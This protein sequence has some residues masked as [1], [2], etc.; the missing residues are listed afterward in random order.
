MGFNESIVL[1]FML[2]TAGL[3]IHHCQDEVYSG[4]DNVLM[5]FTCHMN[6]KSQGFPAEHCIVMTRSLLFSSPVNGFNVF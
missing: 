1:S 5:G 3:S 4:D 2:R 6:A